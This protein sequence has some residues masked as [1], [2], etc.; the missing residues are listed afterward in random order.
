VLPTFYDA[1]AKICNEAL[2]HLR[3]HFGARCLKPVRQATRIKEA[4]AKGQTIF[5]FAPG[6]TPADDYLHVVGCISGEIPLESNLVASQQEPER[7]PVAA[8]A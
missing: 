8:T 2:D 7:A 3:Q 4:P 1:R 5:E 6:S